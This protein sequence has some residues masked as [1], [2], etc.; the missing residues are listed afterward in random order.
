MLFNVDYWLFWGKYCWF[1]SLVLL[2]I[3]E[4]VIRL[5]S[6]AL[7][8]PTLLL[9][10]AQLGCLEISIGSSYTLWNEDWLPNRYHCKV[11]AHNIQLCTAT[12]QLLN[13]VGCAIKSFIIYFFLKTIFRNT[14][15]TIVGVYFMQK[16]QNLKYLLL[17]RLPSWVALMLDYVMRGKI[18]SLINWYINLRKCQVIEIRI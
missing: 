11:S 10:P 6:L 17:S 2:S 7:S 4:E 13:I 5:S 1:T 9:S 16:A 8:S 18:E 12:N 3:N 15:H 14:C